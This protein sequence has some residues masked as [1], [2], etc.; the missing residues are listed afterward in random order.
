MGFSSAQ[1]LVL[2]WTILNSTHPQVVDARKRRLIL[3]TIAAGTFVSVLDQTGVSLA[4]PLMADEF[5]ATIP[6][7]QWVA[8]G[9]ILT[10]GS[11]LL[12]AGR[13]SDLIG[14]KV[15]YVAGFCVF[16]LGAS[17]AAASPNLMAVI[18]FRIL[19]GA[20]SAMIQA[21]GMAILTTTF[22]A[23]QRGR[24]IGMFMTMVGLGAIMG[25]ILAG[26]VV[27]SF[28]WRSVFIA[29]VPLGGL[30]LVAA[31]VVLIR[32]AP[33]ISNAKQL[34]TRFDW[35][36]ALISASGLAIFLLVMTNGYRLGWTSPIV[37]AAF[38][39]SLCL[40]AAFVYWERRTSQPMLEL[41]LFRRR[42]FALGTSASFFGFLAG[43]AV[44]SMMPF[45]LQ[46]V[47][48][49][50]P[51]TA[52]L[53][54]A[55]AALGFAIAGPVAGRLADSLGPRRVEFAGLGM[56]GVSLI[57]LGTLTVDTRPGVVAVAMALQGLGM[58]VFYTPNTA[59]VLSVVER[60]KYGIATA[61]LN[62]TRNTANVVGIGLAITIVTVTM[63]S[64]GFEPSLD[65]V[66]AGGVGV[67]AAFT[68][69]LR[70]AFLILGAF[71][72]V[73]ILLTALKITA[74]EDS[75]LEGSGMGRTKAQVGGD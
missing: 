2:H 44:F 11:L 48:D 20:G 41:A 56:L 28:G 7:V 9:Y 1:S 31:T 49:L 35:A 68:Q 3:L 25:P 66:A 75:V 61:F 37:A 69:G 72:G 15:V 19:Q 30:S 54:I 63:A 39:I 5:D 16:V 24:V 53:Y 27:D 67:E 62:M 40:L 26:V 73:S 13:L 17:L 43:T 34:V 18:V 33:S 38:P 36:G 42:T 47:L 59:S 57:F 50:S 52:G 10:T 51:R 55:P 70:I 46:D 8:L 65:A 64:R 58:G 22:P 4:L 12:P 23:E 29:S 60:S 45:Y 32:D 14:R 6:F 74:R 21:N 71:I